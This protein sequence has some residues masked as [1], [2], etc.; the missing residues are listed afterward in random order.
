[1]D[2]LKQLQGLAGGL[3]WFSPDS[4]VIITTRDK[5]LLTCS[6][7][8]ETTY[9][10]DWLNVAEALELLTWKAFKSNRVHSSY[11]YILPCAITYASGLPLALEV[12]GSNLFGL[13]IGEWESTLDQYERIP[14]KEIQ[15]ILKVLM[16]W[17]KMSKVFFSTL[18]V[19]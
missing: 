7:R 8:V 10:V 9:E 13:D 6:H 5:R 15:K 18:L 11:K 19:A 14:N 17:R 16:L 1:M 3:D 4:R 12:V 2:E